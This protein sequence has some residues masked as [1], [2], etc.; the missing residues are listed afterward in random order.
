M[1]LASNR[2]LEVEVKYKGLLDWI[3]ELKGV[4]L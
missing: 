2:K 3:L 1:N 4:E